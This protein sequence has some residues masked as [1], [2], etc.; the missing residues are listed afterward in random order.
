MSS[1]IDKVYLVT[2]FYDG[3]RSGVASIGDNPI[4]FEEE[5]NQELEDYTGV[6]SS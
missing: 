2:Y 3:V 1:E 5:F 6:F 4:Y